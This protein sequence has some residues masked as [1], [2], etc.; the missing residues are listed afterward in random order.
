MSDKTSGFIAVATFLVAMLLGPTLNGQITISVDDPTVTVGA[1]QFVTFS[2][3]GTDLVDN[4][5]FVTVIDQASGSGPNIISV[6]G[7][8]F[9]DGVAPSF[10][11]GFTPAISPLAVVSLFNNLGDSE[12]IDGTDFVTVEFDTS[13]LSVGDT[14]D[15]D[16]EFGPQTTVFAGGDTQVDANFPSPFVITVTD[17]F[18]LGDV[19]QN[20][21]VNFFDI[22]PFIVLLAGQGF[23]DEADIDR[24]GV[25][26]FFDISPF[27]AIL[28]AN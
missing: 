22:N 10:G 11:G 6:S 14:F 20:G 3:S 1:S 9:F 7:I 16:L 4:L 12:S 2:A 21:V 24:N 26:N 8:G 5:T 19:D 23:L 17:P 28:A 13:G 27:I 25:V 15:I 18:L